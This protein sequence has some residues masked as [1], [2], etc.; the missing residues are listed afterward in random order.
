MTDRTHT[1]A[2]AVFDDERALE[3]AVDEL[4]TAGFDRAHI[5]LLASEA[6]VQQKLGHRYARAEV[7]EDD[8]DAPRAAYVSRNARTEGEA[9]LVGGLIYVPAVAATAAVVASGGTLAM[10]I[11][12]AAAMGGAGGLIGAALARLIERRHADRIQEQIEQGGLVLWVRSI[13]E[14]HEHRA[15]E[16]LTRNGGRDV[17][18]HRLA[19]LDAS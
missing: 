10:A 4:E 5:S 11:A 17:H 6:T 14:D 18:V 9:G 2:V 1:E 12:A 8:P 15:V 13:D 3:S 19:D 16:I 7:A